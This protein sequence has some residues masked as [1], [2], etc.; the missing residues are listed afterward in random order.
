M[1]FQFLTNGATA[2][3]WK[4]WSVITTG[5]IHEL[6][7]LLSKPNNHKSKYRE[8][9]LTR[10]APNGYFHYW[11]TCRLFSWRVDLANSFKKSSNESKDNKYLVY[12]NLKWIKCNK[13]WSLP[14]SN[15]TFWD[16]LV[17]KSVNHLIVAAIITVSHTTASHSTVYNLDEESSLPLTW[18]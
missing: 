6:H 2:E 15:Y 12:F 11:L 16:V 17:W 1:V 10:A 7:A 4:Y 9:I 14:T 18:N 13:F 3:S 8:I 5:Q